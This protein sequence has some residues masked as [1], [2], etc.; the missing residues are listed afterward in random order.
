MGRLLDADTTLL[1]WVNHSAEP[2]K[3][4]RVIAPNTTVRLSTPL[5]AAETF[6]F[7]ASHPGHSAAVTFT[8]EVAPELRDGSMGTWVQAAQVAI[9]AAG[10]RVEA[11]LHGSMLALDAADVADAGEG[12]IVYARVSAS[13]PGAPTGTPPQPGPPV[14]ANPAGAYSGLTY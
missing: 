7:V 8:L 11:P 6:T 4:E 1:G 10:G 13:Q 9:P 12:A 14:P 2:H 3:D 5:D